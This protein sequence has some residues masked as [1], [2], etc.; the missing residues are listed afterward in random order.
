MKGPTETKEMLREVILKRRERVIPQ[1]VETASAGIRAQLVRP[2]F[3]L[4]ASPAVLGAFLPLACEV[5]LRPLFDLWEGAGMEVVVPA[6]DPGLKEYRPARMPRDPNL[7]VRRMKGVL[8][9]DRPDWVRKE[10][11]S[12]WFVPGLA[13]DRHGHRL[14]H[15]QGWFDRLLSGCIHARFCGVAFSW[16]VV[17]RVPCLSHDICMDWMATE[18]GFW[19]STS[20]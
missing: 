4:P 2:E 20:P 9:P 17:D 16:A 3:P 10:R 12:F 5:D 8:E 13:F 1:E 14:G 6:F 18:E 19:R 7:L 15:G 11:V